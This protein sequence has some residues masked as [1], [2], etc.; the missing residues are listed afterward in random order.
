MIRAHADCQIA[1]PLRANP[2]I[3]SLHLHLHLARCLTR[4]IHNPSPLL[5][6]N[7][8]LPLNHL[9]KTA[10][11]THRPSTAQTRP[12]RSIQYQPLLQ[13]ASPTLNIKSDRRL[14]STG[15][16]PRANSRSISMLWI[17][18]GCLDRGIFLDIRHD[19]RKSRRHGAQR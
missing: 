18:T 2:T 10:M 11:H 1:P 19:S 9:L 16:N 8:L 3:L 6:T 5:S 17:V 12:T 13:P 15:S 4:H 7:G 14:L